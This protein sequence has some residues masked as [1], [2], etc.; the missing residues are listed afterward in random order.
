MREIWFALLLVA[1]A[2]GI[3]PAGAQA[4][5]AAADAATLLAVTPQ[6]R[7][8]GKPDAPVTIVEYASLTC[9][10]CAHFAKDVLPKLKPKWIDSGKAKLVMR[11][12]PLD[13]PALRAEMVAR[14]APPAKYYPLIETLFETQDTWAISKDWRSA[15]E[16]T[17]RLAGISKKDFDACLADKAVEDMVVSSRLVAAT[18]LGVNSTPSFFVNGNKFEGVP[19]EQ[20][21]EQALSAVAP[22]S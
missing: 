15:L 6:D 3:G 12:F 21:F 22:K 1:A 7:V 14:C 19:T 16:R 20:A 9:P 2:A 18:Q 17:A 5:K 11:P 4:P 10:H 8:L 13:E